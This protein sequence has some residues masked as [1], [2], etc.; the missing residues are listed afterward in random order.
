MDILTQKELLV[1]A[2]KD[3]RP[4][5]N[6]DNKELSQLALLSKIQVSQSPFGMD[7]NNHLMTHIAKQNPL[8]H[9]DCLRLANMPDDQAALFIER[10]AKESLVEPSKMDSGLGALIKK[11]NFDSA[12][13]LI[14]VLSEQNIKYKTHSYTADF[15][16]AARHLQNKGVDQSEAEDKLIGLMKE[17]PWDITEKVQGRE[18]TQHFQSGN[19]P[20]AYG[21]VSKE[22][23]NNIKQ[24]AGLDNDDAKERA[25]ASINLRPTL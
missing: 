24:N 23:A 16:Q 15:C 13:T 5:I 6:I 1:D 22:M 17:L 2:I 7:E 21:Y 18:I 14:D 25:G 3:K 8:S 4:T 19:I 12:R 10:S 20:T 11:G 9:I